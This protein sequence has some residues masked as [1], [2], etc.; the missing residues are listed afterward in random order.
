MQCIICERRPANT[1]KGYCNNCDAKITADRN[2][3]Q[4]PKPEKYL[5][6]RG[7]VVGLFG[8]GNGGYH[9]ELLSRSIDNI[10]KC[11]LID[12]DHYCDGYTR[13]QVKR[14]KRCCLRLSA[15]GLTKN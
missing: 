8:N 15:I 4:S 7:T 9:A 13:E 1:D 14:F 3:R 6:Y 10:P 11:R 12:L 2:S 5:H